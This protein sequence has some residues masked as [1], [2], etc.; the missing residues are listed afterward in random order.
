MFQS[1][2]PIELQQQSSRPLLFL[3]IVAILEKEVF[4]EFLTFVNKLPEENSRPSRHYWN[5]GRHQDNWT[6][7]RGRV[8]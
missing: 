6:I 8:F 1:S 4:H 2:S 5:G 3:L 7:K